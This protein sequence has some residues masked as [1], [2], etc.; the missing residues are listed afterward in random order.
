MATKAQVAKTPATPAAVKQA[1]AKKAGAA[2]KA[3]RVHKAAPGTVEGPKGKKLENAADAPP[4]TEEQRKGER[5]QE[6]SNAMAQFAASSLQTPAVHEPTEEEKKLAALQD[7]IKA[8]AASL[9]IDP[10]AVLGNAK[11]AKAPRADKVQ[12]NNVTRPAPDTTCGKIWALADKLS[13][14]RG[15]GHPVEVAKLRAHVDMKQVNDHTLKTQFARWRLFNGFKG[16]TPMQLEA[17]A[18]LNRRA[19]DPKPE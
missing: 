9:G 17:A 12:Q 10:A 14:E 11:P 7:G 19:D 18:E 6:V 5:R 1:A 16:R 3:P 2:P 15:D 4:V 8:L 13:T